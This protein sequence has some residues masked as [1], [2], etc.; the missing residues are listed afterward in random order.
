MKKLILISVLIFAFTTLFTG[1]YD[2]VFYEVFMDV[3]PEQPTVSGFINSITRYTV[4]EKEFLTLAADGGV[5][6]KLAEDQ[7]HGSWRTLSNLPFSQ[8]KYNYDSS[9]HDGQQILK[10]MADSSTLYL[11]TASYKE[12]A[13]YGTTGIASIYVW[14]NNSLTLGADN[15][16]WE[17]PADSWKCIVND[18]K[19]F[20]VYF[21]EGYQYSAY[22]AFQTN[23]PKKENRK[24]YI[25]SGDA[26]SPVEA[27]KTP[28]Y[29]E[30]SISGPTA[31]TPTAAD[32]STQNNITSAVCFNGSPVFFNA[33]TA[34]TN[35]TYT[36]DATRI[37][38]GS[39]N[40]LYYSDTNGTNFTR[41]VDAGNSISSLAVCAD[42]IIIGRATYS[43]TSSV[44]Y[45][46]VARVLLKDGIP[47]SGLSEFQT[48]AEFQLSSSY[49]INALLNATPDKTEKESALYSAISFYGTGSSINVSYKNIGLWSYYPGRGNW[50]RE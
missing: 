47:E 34:I 5:R 14:A 13:E 23:S 2:P 50:N 46:G 42:S 4:G 22:S 45:G 41:A 15:V 12:F 7:N 40:V 30:L 21:Y 32:D 9:S 3:K 17:T 26:N 27:Y 35:E 49:L 37:Y 44:A 29:Y 43:T 39:G 31:I 38:Y 8:H 25:R 1:C 20:P 28:A 33:Y 36:K 18:A 10:V 48:N 16:S 19:Y 6:Y 11:M 24:A